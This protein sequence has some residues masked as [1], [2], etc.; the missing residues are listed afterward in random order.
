MK[1]GHANRVGCPFFVGGG[2]ADSTLLLGENR[3]HIR[4]VQMIQRSF[5]Q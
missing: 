3:S 1:N 5:H 4:F 2:L